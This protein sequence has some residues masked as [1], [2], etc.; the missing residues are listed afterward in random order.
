MS[1][2]WANAFRGAPGRRSRTGPPVRLRKGSSVVSKPRPRDAGIVAAYAVPPFSH[3]RRAMHLVQAAQ[4]GF[5]RTA[6]T[7][8]NTPH[9]NPKTTQSYFIRRQK[10]PPN[11]LKSPILGRPFALGGLVVRGG[12][13]S[14]GF[15]RQ[16]RGAH[17]FCPSGVS[18]RN[19]GHA[20]TVC[21]LPERTN[22]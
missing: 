11:I 21:R 13:G 20:R 14:S 17:P 12:L 2:A 3:I 18:Q 4:I 22:P 16:R 19:L 9:I 5:F 6:R 7:R 10:S 15:R 1:S 8:S